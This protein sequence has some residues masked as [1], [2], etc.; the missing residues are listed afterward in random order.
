[1]MPSRPTKDY[2]RAKV[3]RSLQAEFLESRIALDGTGVLLGADAHLTL[4]FAPDGTATANSSNELF[5]TFDQVAPQAEWQ[6]A[7]LTA[8][9][10]WAVETNADIG[11][12]DDNGAPFGSAGATQ[13]DAR[14]GDIRIAAIPMAPE[15]G[16]ISVPIDNVLSGTWYADVVF[17]SNFNYQSV[18]DIFAIALHE[19]G[20]VF[21]LEDNNDPNSPLM[22]G[23]IPTAI[24]PTAS[25][26]AHL[27]AI[28]GQRSHDSNEFEDGDITEDL[29]FNNNLET[30]T[31]LGFGEIGDDEGY[32]PALVYGDITT[33]TDIDF[34]EIQI[35]DDYSGSL[36]I[37]TR[38]EGIS[39]LM[40]ELTVYNSAGTPLQ[41]ESSVEVGG[42]R[43]EITTNSVTPGASYFVSVESAVNSV[44]GIGGFS[45]VGLL[46]DVNTVPQANIDEAADGS[47]RFVPADDLKEVFEAEES[48]FA[49][50][51]GSNDTLESATLLRSSSSFASGSRY[52][53]IGSISVAGDDDYY[54]ITAPDTSEPSNAYI[55]VRSL[56][57]AGLIPS[58][59]VFDESGALLSSR[60]LANGAGQY[61]IEVDSIEAGT[62]LFIKVSAAENSAPF[63]LG[64]YALNISFS[65]SAIHLDSFAVGSLPNSQTQN[66]HTLYV[67]EP[68]LIHLVLQV[69][70]LATD[71]TTAVIAEVVNEAGQ[72]IYTVASQPGQTR[73]AESVFLP[74]GTYTIRVTGLTLDGSVV[75][76]LNYQVLGSAFSDPFV[77]GGEDPTTNPFACDDPA[78]AGFYCYPGDVV[79]SDPFL[80]DNFVTSLPEPAPEVAIN[81]QVQLLIGDWWR[82]FWNSLGVNGRPLAIDDTFQVPVA[83]ISAMSNSGPSPMS[84]ASSAPHNVLANDIEPENE[85]MVAALQSG[86]SNGTVSLSTD[87]SFT[88]TP[89]PG[90][91]GVDQFVYV[92]SD[93]SQS[94]APATVTIV[95]GSVAV[96]SGDFTN[97]GQ[98]DGLDFLLWQQQFGSSSAS[99]ADSNSDG[100][101]DSADLS[102]WEADYGTQAT[103]S[104]ASSPPIA[105]PAPAANGSSTQQNNTTTSEPTATTAAPLTV[106]GPIQLT[107]PEATSPNTA[108]ANEPTPQATQAA[109]PAGTPSESNNTA[110]AQTSTG[111]SPAPTTATDAVFDSMGADLVDSQLP[112]SL[113]TE[114]NPNVL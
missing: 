101:V 113:A 39:L 68:Q 97:D 42:D 28:I 95:V 8:F 49:K 108:E 27:Q 109:E 47:L 104:A 91:E 32:S 83:A 45:L 57:F 107:T 87:G 88:Y 33:A 105:S 25:D 31:K 18:D 21:G 70:D 29:D 4:S 53:T 67:A 84:A 69:E 10:T 61:L 22:A 80:W 16:A 15:I 17:N 60:T 64:N 24:V 37:Q 2:R 65:L 38:T 34:F 59:Q 63:N 102:F 73:S 77:G 13:R 71:T 51:L 79:S 81:E 90:F 78:L 20:N 106:Q 110:P 5:A 111:E 48:F 14:F 40:P 94:S 92:A 55:A 7:I 114:E 50:D 66:Q 62:D 43:L 82:W 26:I 89:N 93:F 99:G 1:M 23:P 36:T 41:S 76:P 86:P 30:A 9:Q 46:D 103:S 54:R 75:G 58:A 35:P 96:P 74:I 52:E 3:G 19:A 72:A 98:I 44:F 6:T 85:T 12:V 112:T 100:I 11:L 56:D